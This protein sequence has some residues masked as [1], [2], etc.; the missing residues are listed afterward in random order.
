VLFATADA[1]RGRLKMLV[2]A[3]RENTDIELQ[4]TDQY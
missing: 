3:A 1:R 4:I 2:L